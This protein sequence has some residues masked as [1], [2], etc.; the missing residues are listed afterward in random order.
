MNEKYKISVDSKSLHEENKPIICY[1]FIE[2]QSINSNVEELA[3]FPFIQP[4]LH[5]P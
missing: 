5:L 4:I 1:S 3:R 2:E